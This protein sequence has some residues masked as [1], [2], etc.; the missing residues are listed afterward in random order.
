VAHL[1]HTP[2]DDRD[3]NLAA[4]CEF[5]HLHFDAPHHKLQRE[6]RK[7]KARP[8]F[9]MIGQAALEIR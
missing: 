7:D 9:E 1:N 8:M 4:L 6:I 3:D 5:C 2:G